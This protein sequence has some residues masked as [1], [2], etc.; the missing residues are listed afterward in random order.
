MGGKT[1]MWDEV[2]RG[3]TTCDSRNKSTF[4][5]EKHVDC[6]AAETQLSP[7]GYWA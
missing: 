1:T 7:S 5:V 6:F 2:E 4:A 3:G